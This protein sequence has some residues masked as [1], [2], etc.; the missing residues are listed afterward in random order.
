MDPEDLTH[1]NNLLDHDADLREKIKDHVTDFDKKSRT[2]VGLL[3]KIHSTRSSDIPP[4]LDTVRPVLHSCRETS[5]AL[6]DLVPADQFWRWKDMWSMSLRQSVFSAILIEYLTNGTLLSMAVTSDQLGIRGEWKDRFVL[7]VEDYL[8]GVITMVN[9]LSRFAV[10]AVTLGDFEA[11]IKISIFVKDLFAGF[12]MLN[13]K[14]D[15]LRRRYDSLKYDIKKIEEVV[16]DVSLRKLA[17][18][19]AKDPATGAEN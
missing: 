15:T 7:S 12:S 8:H 19:R 4:L 2:M 11:P 3:N 1:I 17:S 16:Y 9:E 6:A 5:A 14:N 10:N 18:P 13:L